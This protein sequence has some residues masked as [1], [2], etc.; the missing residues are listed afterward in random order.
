MAVSFIKLSRF[1]YDIQAFSSATVCQSACLRCFGDTS[2]FTFL[3]GGFGFE[4]V[5]FKLLNKNAIPN[6]VTVEVNNYTHACKSDA[7]MQK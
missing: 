2:P 5:D 6:L 4:N 1:Y 7:K 3:L